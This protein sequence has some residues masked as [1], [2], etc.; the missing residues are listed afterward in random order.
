MEVRLSWFCDHQCSLGRC[1]ISRCPAVL[2]RVQLPISRMLLVPRLTAPRLAGIFFCLVISPSNQP[3]LWLLTP[4][5]SCPISS[6]ASSNLTSTSTITYSYFTS[7]TLGRHLTFVRKK[8][9]I[10]V[11]CSTYQLQNYCSMKAIPL[12]TPKF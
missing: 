7:A 6:S 4:A 8:K 5:C 12:L 10:Q 11:C 1:P 9:G 2:Q 3:P